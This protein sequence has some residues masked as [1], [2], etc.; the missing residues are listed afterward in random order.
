VLKDV[1]NDSYGSRIVLIA[2]FKYVIG[3]TAISYDY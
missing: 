1:L 3:L 2:L